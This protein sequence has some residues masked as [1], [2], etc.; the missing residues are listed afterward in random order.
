MYLETHARSLAKA[1]SWRIAGTLATSAI[2]FLVTRRLAFSL[3]IGGAEFVGKIGLYWLHERVWSRVRYGVQYFDPAVIWLTGFSGSGKSTIADQV[4]EQLKQRG[5]RVEQLDGDRVREIFPATGFSRAE[6]D[7]HIRRIGFLASTLERQGVFVIASF[8]SPYAE[9]RDFVRGLCR[10]FIEVH[11]A[12]PI[13]ECERRDVKG[14]YA[15]ARRGEIKQFTGIDDPY[16]PPVN[17]EVTIDT[18]RTTPSDA[19]QVVVRRALATGVA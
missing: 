15:R 11:V 6:R 1:I 12:T 18:M 4:A 14:L 10:K 17:P 16:E 5:H 9:S 13:E 8:V 2:V 7:S 3:A 19:A